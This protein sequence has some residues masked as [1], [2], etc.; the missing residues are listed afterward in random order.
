MSFFYDIFMLERKYIDVGT[1]LIGNL[2]K[3]PKI[4]SLLTLTSI[5]K[6]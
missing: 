3:N 4:K 5:N 1:Q 2:V 6:K